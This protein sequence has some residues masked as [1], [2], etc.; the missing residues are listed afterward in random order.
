MK[1][2]FSNTGAHVFLLAGL[3]SQPNA[4]MMALPAKTSLPPK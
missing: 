2:T 4:W 3:S 1:M